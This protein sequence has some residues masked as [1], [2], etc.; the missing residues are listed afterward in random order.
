M[1][2]DSAL[3]VQDNVSGL[4]GISDELAT[5]VLTGSTQRG[6][7]RGE[8]LSEVLPSL[9][10]HHPEQ[11]FWVVGGTPSRSPTVAAVLRLALRLIHRRATVNYQRLSWKTNSPLLLMYPQC[12][13]TRTAARLPWNSLA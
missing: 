2:S 5:A 13:P 8:H 7:S 10:S 3:F 9:H 6:K 12:G 4:H 11:A 1:G